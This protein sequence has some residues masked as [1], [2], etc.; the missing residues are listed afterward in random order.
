MIA[1][2]GEKTGRWSASEHALF[3][4]GL[5]LH[6]RLWRKIAAMSKT[7]SIVQ[8]R[9]H[10]QKYFLKQQNCL[11]DHTDHQN[12]HSYHVNNHFSRSRSSNLRVMQMNQYQGH[13]NNNNN[14]NNNG[15]SSNYNNNNH[16]S[17]NEGNSLIGMKRYRN[18][19]ELL[20]F[21]SDQSASHSSS[22]SASALFDSGLDLPDIHD[23]EDDDNTDHETDSNANNSH[24]GSMNDD[25]IRH[26][27]P[28]KIQ[29]VTSPEQEEKRMLMLDS[30]NSP[31][32]VGFTPYLDMNMALGTGDDKEDVNNLLE[33]IGGDNIHSCI[34]TETDYSKAFNIDVVETEGNTSPFEIDHENFTEDKLSNSGDR[35]LFSVFDDVN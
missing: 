7:R 1:E 31:T 33:E 32:S 6:G 16:R 27:K 9:T 3:L 30:T 24:D 5:N 17:G 10:A 34:E 11:R 22:A 28:L 8:I 26:N 14:N 21:I 13:S 19:N 15:S 23:N 4:E 18:D 29:R 2:T 12:H 35:D 20:D 25:I